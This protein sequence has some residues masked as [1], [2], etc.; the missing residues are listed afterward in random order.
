LRQFV[1]D[2]DG[3]LHAVVWWNGCN[4]ISGMGISHQGTYGSR[5]MSLF[6]RTRSGQPWPDGDGRLHVQFP[7]DDLF[8]DPVGL[9][10]H[11]VAN[12][13]LAVVLPLLL[14]GLRA[15]LPA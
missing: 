4:A 9:L 2:F 8:A 10:S 15:R 12:H 13:V 11:R 7:V 14:L 5:I 6:T 1:A 3:Q